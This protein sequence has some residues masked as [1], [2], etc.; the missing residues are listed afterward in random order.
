MDGCSICNNPTAEKSRF[1][2]QHNRAHER[3]LSAYGKWRSGYG[4]QMSWRAFL[5]R[6]SQLSET[7]Q[8]AQDVIKFLLETDSP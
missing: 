5:L 3:L 8:K 1:C 2:K 6:V 4:D 7:G